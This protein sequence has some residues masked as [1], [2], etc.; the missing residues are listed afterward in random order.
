[1]REGRLRFYINGRTHRQTVAPICAL[2]SEAARALIHP[3][4]L[5]ERPHH[6]GQEAAVP[7][8]IFGASVAL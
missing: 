5:S 3:L 7:H 4:F 1:M 6:M 2:R 8:W